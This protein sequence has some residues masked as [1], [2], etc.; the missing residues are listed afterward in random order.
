MQLE[1]LDWNR[2]G[3]I[4]G[5]TETEE[6]FR[7][8][9]E[10]EL[11]LKEQL[12]NKTDAIL[13]N[14]A[15]FD[16]ALLITEKLYDISPKWLPAFYSNKGLMFWEGGATWVSKEGLPLVHLRRS[17]IKKTRILG[18]YERTILLAHE[19]IH[20]ARSAFH[21]PYFEEFLAYNT[22]ENK[23]QRFLGSLVK[24]PVE[25]YLFLASIWLSSVAMGFGFFEGLLLPF[26]LIGAVTLRS[27]FRQKKW[28]KAH[29]TLKD[30]VYSADTA[31]FI[32]FRMSD[33]EIK[34]FAKLSKEE[35]LSFIQREKEK[36]LR[37]QIIHAA[38]F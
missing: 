3:F 4:P 24:S 30:I 16:E 7:E 8:R 25:V 1:Y 11:I 17:F 14:D 37:W 26:L 38:Y 21:E 33:K 34:H 18:L 32:L 15:S 13:I 19:M 2:K 36:S 12:L 22:S 29:E 23:Y 6:A 5:P 28:K 27:V 31:R 20:A 9:V 35:I 10:I